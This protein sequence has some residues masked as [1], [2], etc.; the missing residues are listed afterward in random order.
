M[1][2]ADAALRAMKRY[3]AATFW[4]WIEVDRDWVWLLPICRRRGEQAWVTQEPRE[5][6]RGGIDA[7]ACRE[8]GDEAA[9]IVVVEMHEGAPRGRDAAPELR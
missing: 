9:V 2:L 4:D 1:A 3:R 5:I 6:V 8:R 7:A